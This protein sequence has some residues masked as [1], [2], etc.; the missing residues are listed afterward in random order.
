MEVVG[1][2]AEGVDTMPVAFYTFLQQQHEATAVGII[3]ENILTVVASQHGVVKGRWIVDSWFACHGGILAS[4][5]I[6]A[7]LTL[8]FHCWRAD[9]NCKCTT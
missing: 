8:K 5:C 4:N 7:S 1:H 6:D 2:Q 3:E 9:S